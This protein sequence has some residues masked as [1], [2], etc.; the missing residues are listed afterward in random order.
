MLA[1]ED[2]SLPC[3][4]ESF[5]HLLSHSL[6]KQLQPLVHFLE[7]AGVTREYIKDVILLFPPVMFYDIEGDL[8]QRIQ[9]LS[10]VPFHV[11]YC[12]FYQILIVCLGLHVCQVGVEGKDVGKMLVRYPWIL[13]TCIME[14]INDVYT[15]LSME[16]VHSP[17]SPLRL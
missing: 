6:Q 12:L 9:A 14:N 4:V 13:S 2:T 5:P 1:D 16:K 7:N 8:T 11:R 17:K 10:K 3:L 15:F